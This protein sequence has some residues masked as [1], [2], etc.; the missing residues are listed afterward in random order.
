M[1]KTQNA[2]FVWI[3]PALLAL[4]VLACSG[5]S[6]PEATA[7]PLPRPTQKPNASATTAPAKPTATKAAAKPTATQKADQA[8]DAAPT[9]VATAD[10]SAPITL[11]STP[12]KHKSGAF[13]VT[14]PDGWSPQ[15][16]D[17][18]VYAE[19]PDKVASID[20]SFTNVGAKFDA[21]TLDTFIKA[22]GFLPV[23][24]SGLDVFKSEPALKVYIDTLPNVHLTPNQDPVWD[25]VLLAVQQQIGAA[26]APNGDPKKVLD[27][28]QKTAEAGG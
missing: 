3:V 8:T 15:E 5:G 14:L 22:E 21:A 2:R 17:N 4:A 13:T 1:M 19:S 12:F 25:K 6:A 10:G 24:K 9:D 26:V 16:A 20:I 7:T 11:S 27:A 23:T 28:L 18:S